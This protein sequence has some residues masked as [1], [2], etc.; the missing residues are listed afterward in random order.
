MSFKPVGGG[1]QNVNWSRIARE[2]KEKREGKLEGG[3]RASVKS[4]EKSEAAQRRLS[5]TPTAS[6]SNSPAMQRR[7]VKKQEKAPRPT[8]PSRHPGRTVFGFVFVHDDEVEFKSLKKRDKEDFVHDLFGGN[9]GEIPDYVIESLTPEQI[10]NLDT[11]QLCQ[12]TRQ[13]FKMLNED[14]QR[15]FVHA[16]LKPHTDPLDVDMHTARLITLPP[17]AYKYIHSNQLVHFTKQ[18]ILDIMEMENNKETSGLKDRNIPYHFLDPAAKAVITD[19]S[20]DRRKYIVENIKNNRDLDSV[21]RNIMSLDPGDCQAI[22]LKDLTDMV[23]NYNY[24]RDCVRLFDY[25]QRRAMKPEVREW[26]NSIK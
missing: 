4:N 13:Q 8:P 6:P 17:E 26:I 2:A 12:L 10:A 23:I 20:E 16:I 18:A 21:R 7:S 1:D 9:V 14:T 24:I 3:R 25:D 5:N 22:E 19:L 15:A 11:N